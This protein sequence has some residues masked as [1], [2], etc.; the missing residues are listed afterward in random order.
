LKQTCIVFFLDETF[1]ELQYDSS[2]SV[3]EAVQQLA[4]QIKLE[5]FQT[6]TLFAVHKVGR[7]PPVDVGVEVDRGQQGALAW[8]R[9][10]SKYWRH[11]WLD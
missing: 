9:S 4:S 11:G 6:F 2:T 7:V 5:A 1:E 8:V 3:G 10:L